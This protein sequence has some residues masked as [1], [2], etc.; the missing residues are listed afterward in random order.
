MRQ[1]LKDFSFLFG[2][3]WYKTTH[4][5]MKWLYSFNVLTKEAASMTVKRLKKMRLERKS[6]RD[7][8]FWMGI[9]TFL[10]KPISR[11]ELIQ[12]LQHLLDASN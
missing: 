6:G 3:Q 2:I 1:G 8:G 4:E 7:A 5:E 10:M 11:K 9:D 12:A